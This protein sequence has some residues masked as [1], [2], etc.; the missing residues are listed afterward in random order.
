[1][2]HTTAPERSLVLGEWQ[3]PS[4]S[5]T[6]ECDLTEGRLV[7]TRLLQM[8]KCENGGGVRSG[9]MLPQSQGKSVLTKHRRTLKNFWSGTI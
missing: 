7:S 2:K 3:L 8:K 1:M 5:L 6:A 9:V 4:F